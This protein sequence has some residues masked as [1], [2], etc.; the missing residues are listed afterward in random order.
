MSFGGSGH[1]SHVGNLRPHNEDSYLLD[2]ELG[3]GVLADG[4]GGYEGGEIA[5]RIV[6]QSVSDAVRSGASMAQSLV[7]AHKAVLAAAKNGEGRPGMGS[8]A[9]AIKLTDHDY[10]VV[11]V[12]DSRAYLWNTEQLVQL[13]TDHSLVQELVEQGEISV[14]EARCHPKRNLITQAIGMSELHT[15]KVGVVKGQVFPGHQLLLCSDG[16]SGEVTHGEIAEILALDLN[17]Q[18]KVDLLVQRALENGGS[19]NITVILIS[20]NNTPTI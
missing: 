12:G 1:D 20:A 11:W 16:L 6:V 5:S 14:E 10:E 18:Q 17:E 3:L 9:L 2:A 8:T 19:D 4:M 13:T 7:T 15:M